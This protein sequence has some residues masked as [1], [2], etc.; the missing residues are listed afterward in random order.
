MT[1]PHSP[2][3]QIADSY[4][5]AIAALNPL[6][7]TEIG[8][9]RYERILPDLSPDGRLAVTDLQRSTLRSLASSKAVLDDTDTVTVAAM[10][11]RLGLEIER[12]EA[13]EVLRELN[14]LASAP[15]NLREVFDL[16]PTSTD[17]NWSDIAAR[18]AAI[19]AALGGYQASLALA[20]TR[21]QVAAARQ[22]DKVAIECVD[23]AGQNGFFRSFTRGAQIDSAALR[24][25]LAAGT[26]AAAAA[27]TALAEFLRTSLLPL[28][29]SRDAVGRE[30][31]AL[32]SRY[33]LGAT[34][35]LDETYSWGLRELARIESEMAEVAD[36]IVPGGDLDAA[37]HALDN[38]PARMIH[39]KDQFRQWMQDLSDRTIA[40]MGR[41]HFDIP[42]AIRTLDCKIAP[43]TTGSIYYLAPD[44]DFT[45]PGSMWWTVPEGIE[46][47]STWREVTTVYHEGVPGH[48]L[49]C[50]QTAYRRK[51]LNRWRRMGCWV[52]GHGEGW[53]LY[54]ER[55]M[56]ELG[57]LDEP[58][59]YLGMLDGQRLRAARV[60]LDIG[61]HLQLPVPPELGRGNWNADNA[62]TF[63]TSH[64]R[65]GHELLAFELN[66]YLGWPG[67][68][69]SYK[70]G[71]RIW[72]ELREQV[73][74]A[75]GADF[76]LT[77]F[78]RQALDLGSLGL[79]VL[80][81]A[82]LE[83]NLRP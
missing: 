76:D 28:A 57:Y 18:L 12:A 38:D 75:Q 64:A 62:W 2:T 36:R 46:D 10:N 7:A 44:E 40:E 42:D 1:H 59:A 21:G 26:D 54:A 14:V 67:Q 72:L 48:H 32:S 35:D 63:L 56:A 78:H 51:Q 65:M 74:S 70:I 83:G 15:Q 68:A 9:P 52:S 31:Y 22:I 11:E 47:F 41:A 60:V 82:L 19:P 53:A 6:L 13:G 50:A 5:G 71:E 39:G 27:Y 79:D 3:D 33:F 30:R 16:M 24:G 77:A 23:Y 69:P 25:E 45:R 73:R 49:Q 20:A 8:T 4:I 17:D 34:V 66:R 80:R 61:V 37:V 81:A 43:T 55:L 29:P 58:G